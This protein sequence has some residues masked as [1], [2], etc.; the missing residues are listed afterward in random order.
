MYLKAEEYI[1]STN[2]DK[3]L[4]DFV[5]NEK[6]NEIVATA[7]LTHLY[8]GLFGS[9]MTIDV[10]MGYWRK[11]NQ[12]HQWF[13][14]NC[15]DGEDN[16]QPMFVSRDHLEQLKELCIKVIANP[17]MADDEL[18]SQSGFFFGS[19]EYDEYYFQDLNDTIEIITNALDSPYDYFRYQAS[20]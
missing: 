4:N 1:P 19:T 2:F 14:D 5:P 11:A 15:G 17:E 20:W 9:G 12:I 10:P 7:G 13:V 6:F 3:E 8:T 18:P 16:C